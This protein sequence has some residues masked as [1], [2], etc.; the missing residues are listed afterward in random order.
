MNLY[1]INASLLALIDNETGEIID[2]DKFNSLCLSKEEKLDNYIKFYKNLSSDIEQLKIEE[3]KLSERR[4]VKQNTVNWLLENI[5]NELNGKK[6]ETPTYKVSWRK[7]NQLI[8][9]DMLKIPS[10]YVLAQA[11]KVDK[12]AIKQD[13]KNGFEVAG[14]HLEE[15]QN[16]NIK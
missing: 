4:R 10:R 3:N 14:V 15:Y 1:E 11:P 6:L 16:I 7:S 2:I 8:V 13:I 12:T 9:D 5:K